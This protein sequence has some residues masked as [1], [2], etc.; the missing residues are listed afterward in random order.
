MSCILS[1]QT[2]STVDGTILKCCNSMHRRSEQLPDIAG[3]YCAIQDV[4]TIVVSDGFELLPAE[5][6]TGV[7]FLAYVGWDTSVPDQDS[8][9]LAGYFA[10]PPT[11][12]A[13]RIRNCVADRRK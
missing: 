5:I 6:H 4:G 2:K 12:L 7:P 8:S 10:H 13:N 11:D 3:W 9:P 1:S